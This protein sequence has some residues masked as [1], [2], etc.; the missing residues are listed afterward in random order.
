MVSTEAEMFND[1]LAKIAYKSP[2][3]QLLMT[4]PGV[5]FPVAKTLLS[6]IGD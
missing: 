1:H 3:I 5:D 4:L 2:Q 6:M